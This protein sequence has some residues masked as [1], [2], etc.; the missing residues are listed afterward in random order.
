MRPDRWAKK[1]M[2]RAEAPCNWA[3]LGCAH[4]KGPAAAGARGCV[5]TPLFQYFGLSCAQRSVYR[6]EPYLCHMQ[7]E[8]AGGHSS[9]DRLC[10]SGLD[11][12]IEK[13]RIPGSCVG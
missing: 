2:F 5:Q 9:C 10:V 3:R 6:S 7:V 1:F 8:K 11:V 12:K 13:H 4:I